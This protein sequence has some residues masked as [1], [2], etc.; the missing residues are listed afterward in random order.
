MEWADS[1]GIWSG[2]WVKVL[3][4]FFVDV[5]YVN[6]VKESERVVLNLRTSSYCLDECF[7]SCQI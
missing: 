7:D 6:S 5:K 2:L 3:F 4:S 1:H